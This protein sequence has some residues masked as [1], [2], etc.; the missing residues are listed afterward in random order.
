LHLRHPK[1]HKL[2]ELKPND[3]GMDKKLTRDFENKMIAGVVAGLAKYFEHDVTLWRL[4]VV[5]GFVLTGI[6]PGL[7]L[8]IIAWIIMPTDDGVRDVEYVV[9]E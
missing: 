1:A 2:Q 9:N 6:M 7:L 5:L 3:F 4:A 8:Y